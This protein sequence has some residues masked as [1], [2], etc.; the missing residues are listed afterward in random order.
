[1]NKLS[2]IKVIQMKDDNLVDMG[3]DTCTINVVHEEP[4][5]RAKEKL[6][7]E[8][9]YIELSETFKIFGNPTRLKIMSLLSVEDLCVCDISEILDMSQSAVSHQ[10][11]TLR[12]RNLVKYTREGKQARYSLADKH[13]I[14]ILRKGTEHVLE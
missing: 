14:E 7:K 4:M 5:K 8:D 3:D 10:L 2:Y 1:M 6:F 12:S 13:V 9:T 11:R